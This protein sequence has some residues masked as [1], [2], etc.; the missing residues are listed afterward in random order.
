M[1][2]KEVKKDVEKNKNTTTTTGRYVYM[3][4]VFLSKE[5]YLDYVEGLR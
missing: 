2:A 1:S 4:I 5:E 3:G